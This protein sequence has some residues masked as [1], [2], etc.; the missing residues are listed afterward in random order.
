MP[1]LLEVDRFP[2]SRS[3]TQL[4]ISSKSAPWRQMLLSDE[5]A[6]ELYKKLEERFRDK[7]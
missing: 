2:N 4:L 3:G 1:E 7:F 5:E 6:Y